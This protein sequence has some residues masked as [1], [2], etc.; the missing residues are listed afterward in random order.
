M[1]VEGGAGGGEGL[2]AAVHII[3]CKFAFLFMVKL[4]LMNM[5]YNI[6]IINIIIVFACLF[7]FNLLIYF[8]VVVVVVVFK[9]ELY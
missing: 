3:I 1:G 4:T 6:L 7:F 5:Y 8:F 2:N 9:L